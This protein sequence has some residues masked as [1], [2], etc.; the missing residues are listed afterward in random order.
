[1]PEYLVFSAHEPLAEYVLVAKQLGLWQIK[2]KIVMQ[3]TN[4]S[5]ANTNGINTSN[6]YSNE[7]MEMADF[8]LNDGQMR[9]LDKKASINGHSK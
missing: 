7:L 9:S 2:S 5:H 1:M 8:I 3:M 6:L 4:E